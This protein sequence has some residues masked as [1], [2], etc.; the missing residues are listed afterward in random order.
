ML[1]SECVLVCRRGLIETLWNCR[2]IKIIQLRDIQTKKR[3][4]LIAAAAE[5]EKQAW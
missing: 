2:L 3:Y 5:E 4:E 1:Y